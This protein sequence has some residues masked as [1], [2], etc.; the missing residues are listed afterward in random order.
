MAY[1]LSRDGRDNDVVA[2]FARYKG[3]LQSQETVFPPRAYE[4]ATAEWFYD[5]R[6]H[7]CPHDAWLESCQIVKSRDERRR[8]GPCS[9]SIRLLGAYHDGHI[10]IT[11]PNVFSYSLMSL[12]SAAK[13][14]GDW[15]YDEF[16]LSESNHLIHEIEWSGA[17]GPLQRSFSWTIEADDIE[18]EWELVK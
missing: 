9:I 6:D 17:P 15:R 4:L 1:I 12:S 16:R 11:Y 18:F 2:A 10:R 3:F 8:A 13:S 7:R 14:H 5:P